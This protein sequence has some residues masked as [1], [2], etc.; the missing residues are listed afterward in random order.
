MSKTVKKKSRR[1][2]RTVRKTLG[3]LFL[4][5]ALVIAAI[6]VDG[7][8]AANG[9]STGSDGDGRDNKYSWIPEC[10]VPSIKDI[11][12]G[13][14][15]IYVDRDQ[16]LEFV[17][18]K[19]AN[20]WYVIITGYNG[21]LVTEGTL[22][23]PDE[24]SAYKR[25]NPNQ[26]GTGYAAVGRMGNFLFYRATVQNTYHGVANL[27]NATLVDLVKK[28]NPN[29]KFVK[30][31]SDVEETTTTPD[32]VEVGT[33]KY[34]VVLEEET[35]FFLPCYSNQEAVWGE[36]PDSRIYYDSGHPT[37]DDV[38][39]STDPANPYHDKFISVEGDLDHQHVEKVK[40]DY[41]AKEYWNSTGSGSSSTTGDWTLIGQN[42]R[43]QGV[44][45]KETNF[46]RVVLGKNLSGVGNYAFYATGITEITFTN[47]LR[48]IGEGA[49]RGCT[50]LDSVN[51][52]TLEDQETSLT[53]ICAYAFQDCTNLKRFDVPWSVD[54]I[55]DGVF[56]GCSALEEVQMCNTGVRLEHVGLDVFRGCTSLKSLTF[57]QTCK[58]PMY[59]SSFAGCTALQFICAKAP[60][61]TFMDDAGTTYAQFKASV[62]N[63][64]Y[65]EGQENSKLQEMCRDPKGTCHTDCTDTYFAFSYI[66]S[67]F[68]QKG[69]YELTMKDP[70]TT[71]RNIF[72][73]T[74][75]NELDQYI[76][77]GDVK[78]LT[79]PAKIGPYSIKTIRGRSGD[80]EGAFANLCNLQTVVIPNTVEAVGD[81]AF[82][83]CHNLTSVI[84]DGFNVDKDVPDNIEIGRNAF[85]TQ[86]WTKYEGHLNGDKVENA[87]D[88]TPKN[89]LAFIGPVSANFN[90][91]KYA[92]SA[93][94][95]YNNGSQTPSYI[96][97]YTGWPYNLKIEYAANNESKLKD[98]PALSELSTY[99]ASGTPLDYY[100]N[101]IEGNKQYAEALKTAKGK[102]DANG[103]DGLTPNEQTAINAALNVTIPDGITSIEDGLFYNKGVFNQ[104][105]MTV[106]AYSSLKEIKSGTYENEK[107]K[108]RTG[109]F[110]GCEYLKGIN[111]WPGSGVAGTVI[112]DSAFENCT[113]LEQASIDDNSQL[114]VCPFY[115][116]DKLTNVNFGSNPT[117]YICKDSIIYAADNDGNLTVILECLGGKTGYIEPGDLEGVTA[118]RNGAFKGSNVE[119]IDLAKTTVTTIPPETFADTPGL[120]RL[121]FPST[122]TTIGQNAFKGS[123]VN[124]I[125]AS[126]ASN[127]LVPAFIDMTAFDGLVKPDGSERT[128]YSEVTWVCEEG[129]KGEEIGVN[130]RFTIKHAAGDAIWTVT[131][132]DW[133]SD[134]GQNVEVSS[135]SVETGDYV[136]DLPEPAGRDGMV[137]QGW[138]VRGSGDD[139]TNRYP[140]TQDMDVEASYGV[141]PPDYGKVVVSFLDYDG[142]LIKKVSVEPGTDMTTHEEYKDLI[143]SPK[144]EGFEFIGWDRPL[145]NI[146]ANLEVMAQ[147]DPLVE[148]QCLVRYLVD[149]TV[150]HQM[151]VMAGDQAASI[152][153]PTVAGKVFDRWMPALGVVTKDTDYYA[154]FKDD[155]GNQGGNSGSGNNPG[156]PDGPAEGQH[157]LQVQGGSGSGYYAKDEQ[158]VITA[159]PPADG[160]EFSGW[161]VSPADTVIVDKT[162]AT[163]IITMPDKDVAVIANYKAKNGVTGSGNTGSGN[164]VRHTL[165]VR[166]GSG[167]GYYAA[168][169]QIIITADEPARGQVFSGWTVSPANTVVTD[170]TLSAIIITM[171]N[172]DVALIANYKARSTSGTTVTGSSSNTNS[173]R[174]GTSIG[175]VGG[176]TTVVIDK[177][178]LS[179]TGVVSA[180]VNGSTDNF[181]IKITESTSATEAVLRA[182]QAEY[183]NLDNLKYFPMDISLYDSTG[184]TKITDTTGLS[185]SITLP[186]PDSLITYA[187]NNKVAGVVNDRLDKLTPRFTTINGVPC[188]TFTA[189]HFSPYVIYVDLTNLSDG[190]ISD[191]TPT[192]GDGI[193]PKWF[194][195]IGLACLSFVMFM[196]KDNKGGSRNKGASRKQKV[197][198]KVRN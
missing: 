172:N 121:L 150:F 51:L 131:F 33:G 62:S 117:H 96:T 138:K 184:N 183:G 114:G 108:P 175:T 69:L 130:K 134:R 189:E 169:E 7:L 80:T 139:F 120:R 63:E 163:T 118:L 168:G 30:K 10:E 60:E 187:G 21:G 27:D 145:T 15:Q 24:I 180:T 125:F 17:Y 109:T 83:G 171:P 124:Y 128:D 73:V 152:V 148:G 40:V 14:P 147:Y 34:T 68:V 20:N 196:I 65:F 193:H 135:A 116:C 106:T 159:N 101:F 157:T 162:R 71:G 76:P 197:A 119:Q 112:G 185:V 9:T 1:M 18:G 136:L 13:N 97:Y 84:F 141:A 23:I 158:I 3:T 170:K 8:R 74:K 181:T 54:T 77:Q 47:A 59:L 70:Q 188:I 66:D 156:G 41:I 85:Q 61:L 31:I 2:W 22:T 190:T 167:S 122:L 11:E 129:T 137:F 144:R 88:N 115:G 132:W 164:G 25:Y 126:N 161:D 46:S 28:S 38:P 113:R 56:L 79:I 192:T 151:R 89:K 49:F 92:M 98:F 191:N 43:E 6:P 195:S 182:L 104:K 177:N 178:G 153:P 174:P 107:L 75:N 42:N 29:N 110:A 26:G 45:A 87:P 142:T 149:G 53:D 173:N 52:V 36:L 35:G 179:N 32:G 111:L 90:P 5:S 102:Y 37:G 16:N 198:V 160:M 78:S 44:F 72:V 81:Y 140:V 165:Q 166:G 100:Y 64:F 99:A 94:G 4:V 55:G 39:D 57:P 194:L 105:E 127:S 155:N 91:F 48:T 82:V 86:E 58:E 143:P 19:I 50:K 67:N 146:T 12:G 93:A 133:N 176:G 186:L 103:L 95:A 123:A 154:I